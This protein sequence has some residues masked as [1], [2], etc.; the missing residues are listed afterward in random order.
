LVLE[1]LSGVELVLDWSQLVWNS[2]VLTVPLAPGRVKLGQN[3][4]DRLERHTSAES[5]APIQCD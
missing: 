3:S 4:S 1:F 5:W 2:G